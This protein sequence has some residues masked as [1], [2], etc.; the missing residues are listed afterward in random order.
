MHLVAQ[1]L[2]LEEFDALPSKAVASHVIVAFS[3]V[4]AT[5]E[6]YDGVDILGDKIGTF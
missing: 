6:K 4:F 3:S 1:L 2:C 5:Q